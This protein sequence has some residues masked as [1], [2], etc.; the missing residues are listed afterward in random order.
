[1]SKRYKVGIVGLGAIG[2]QIA[3]TIDQGNISNFDLVAIATR[4]EKKAAKN[5]ET[6]DHLP[7]ITSIKN[8]CTRADI[9]VE[10]APAAIFRTI[11]EETIKAGKTLIPASV[12]ALLPYPDVIERAKST[13]A[14]IIVP[15]GALIGLDAVRAAAEG[16]IEKITLK[17]RKPPNGLAGAPFLVQNKISVENL[18]EAKLVFDGSARDGAK[19]FPANVNVAAALS[20]AGI[21]PD[22]TK[23]QIWA[24]PFINRNMHTISV[25][26]DS[27]RF[28]MTIENIPTIENPKTGKITA[29]SL[30]AT[31]KR[32][33][34]PMIAG[35]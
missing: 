35:T 4:D 20:L 21:G 34:E 31:L 27:A 16:N 3:R 23:L 30:I 8:V 9:I 32:F 24:D 11:I 14:K 26:A 22:K 15:T 28:T 33:T 17:T 29:L 5:L 6:F 13:G 10:C 7:D 12:G 19:G 18:T 1:M 25:E 2:L